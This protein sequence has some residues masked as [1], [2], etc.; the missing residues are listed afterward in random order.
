[1][2]VEVTR[3][4][5]RPVERE[6]WARAA[7]R[8]QFSGCNKLLY[9]SA[10]TQES[11]NVSQ[12]AHI[13]AFS[14]NG[15]RGW[16]LFKTKP[17]SL[18]DVSNLMLMCYDCHKK[19][20]QKGSEDRYPADLLISWKM[21]H[22]QRIEILT[23]ID[24]DRKSNVVLYGAN[25]GTERSPI[26]YHG[27][28]EAMFP[29]WYPAT[30]KPVTLSMVSE[31]KD[32]S[33][34]YWQAESQHLTKRFQSKISSI[35]EEDSCKHFSL[36]ALAPQPLL[37]KLGALL[38]DKIDVETYQLHRE[39][40]GWF[41]QDCSD[42]F[43]YIINRPQ[44]MEGKPALVLSLS[45]HVSHERITRVIGPDTSIWEVTI[46]QPHNDFMQSK[47]Q[48]SLF[49]K[50]IRKLIVE[51]KNTHGDATSL[52]IFPVMPVSCAVELGRARM[53]KADM[54][55][56]IYDHDIKTQQFVMAIELRG[57]LHE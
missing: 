49:R 5:K 57:D 16:G 51:I 1:M 36:F 27:C 43:E 46:K 47:Q 31:L 7:A 2:V 48:L 11:V 45:D 35:I 50:C 39:P 38:T 53:P 14:E 34:Q 26:N 44:N 29:N 24:P 3:H 23:G 15:P 28:V 30:E 54:P 10:V 42:D 37:I 21:Q 55:W 6:L 32:H 33:E 8:C 52:Q 56:L 41:W 9:K 19:I 18:N 20:D 13:Y 22:E 12:N 4:I 25:I 40:K 17:T